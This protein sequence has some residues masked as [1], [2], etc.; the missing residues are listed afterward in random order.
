MK[1]TL[2]RIAS[3]LGYEIRK[4]RPIETTPLQNFIVAL[5]KS[6]FEPKHIVD[7]GAN[8]GR[9]TRNMIEY[10]PNSRYSLFEPQSQL[11][12]EI[13]D[14]KSAYN[15][16]FYPF[17]IGSKDTTLNFTIHPREDSCSFSYSEFDAKKL[18]WKQIQADIKRLDNLLLNDIRTICP[19]LVKIDAE[20][21]DLEVLEGCAGL[22]G[23]TD[24]FL[25]EAGV[26][27]S[28]IPNSLTRVND[29]MESKGYKI[30]DITDLN[31]P[32]SNRRLHLIEVVYVNCNSEFNTCS[33]DPA[34]ST[35]R[36]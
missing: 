14:L 11:E 8:R 13:E 36:K 28:E 18:G 26:G 25:I 10:F 33:L 20:G 5:L 19:E 16:H 30:F 4:K 27:H 1:A 22:F 9:W 35:L 32:F 6:G 21:I 15:V 2:K 24:F 34:F 31:R 29:F 3:K 7:I 17:G 23:K 12:Y